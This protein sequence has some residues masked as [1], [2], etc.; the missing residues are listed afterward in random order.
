MGKTR[1]SI[2]KRNLKTFRMEKTYT[3]NK[4][5]L[6]LV[7]QAGARYGYNQRSIMAGANGNPDTHDFTQ[8]METL[9]NIIGLEDE[10]PDDQAARLKL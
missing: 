4:K 9:P 8:F 2:Q 6:L 1:R 5:D 7:F 10:F 3:L